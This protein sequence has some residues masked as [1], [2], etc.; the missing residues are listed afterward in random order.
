MLTLSLHHAA[1]ILCAAAGIASE[2]AAATAVIFGVNGHAMSQAA[3]FDVPLEEQLD[4]LAECGA[5]WYRVDITAGQFAASTDRF[6]SLLAAADKRGVRLLP[7][8]VQEEEVWTLPEAEVR[9][10]AGSFAKSIVQRYRGRITHWE[11]GNELDVPALVRKGERTRSG[12]EWIWE[13]A[14]DGSSADDYHPERLKRAQAFIAGLQEGVKGADE[15]AITIVNTSGWLHHGFIEVLF[16]EEPRI[17]CDI[18]A[19]HWYSEM[20]D[21]A[22]VRGSLDLLQVLSAFRRPLWITEINRRDGSK[23]GQDAA[24]ADYLRTDVARLA[25]HRAVEAVFIYELL[26]QPYFGAEG[27]S[28]Y[29]LVTVERSHEGRWRTGRKKAAF[30]EWRKLCT[31]H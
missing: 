24:M 11:L 28:D 10:K 2:G 15:R 17:G 27:E 7:V 21:M 9:Q 19:W 30:A 23:G 29:G 18:L 14:P 26:D 25:S 20:G 1:L 3:Y 8:L 6:D 12:K 22:K 5:G 4:L 31:G 13:G 16:N